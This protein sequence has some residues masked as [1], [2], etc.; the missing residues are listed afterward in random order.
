M[1]LSETRALELERFKRIKRIKILEKFFL[2]WTKGE[3]TTRVVMG[4][5]KVGRSMD[6][7]TTWT[8]TD[9]GYVE[10]HGSGKIRGRPQV[11]VPVG[12][13][14]QEE[15]L[16]IFWNE[17]EKFVQPIDIHDPKNN[18]YAVLI[19]KSDKD[20]IAALNALTVS[21][22]EASL[23]G[24]NLEKLKLLLAEDFDIVKLLEIDRHNFSIAFLTTPALEE[25]EGFLFKSE[26]DY[27][28]LVSEDFEKFGRSMVGRIRKCSKSYS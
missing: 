28:V 24:Q 14:E 11:R 22:K 25:L 16:R 5:M 27:F 18:N 2:G 4:P 6:V 1:S 12:R 8:Y 7:H 15:L 9:D 20:C 26:N 23:A 19:P 17:V 21:P 10:I 13:I 3:G